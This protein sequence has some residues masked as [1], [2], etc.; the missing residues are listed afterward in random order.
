MCLF[1]CGIKESNF[2][3]SAIIDPDFEKRKHNK[4]YVIKI[5][6]ITGHMTIIQHDIN[7]NNK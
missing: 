5:N 3:P 1:K 6:L 4:N 2:L 7:T